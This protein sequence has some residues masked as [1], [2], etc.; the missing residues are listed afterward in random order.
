MDAI[1]GIDVGTSSTK[2]VGIRP[3]GSIIAALRARGAH[4]ITDIYDVL[5]AFL[6]SN[7]LTLNDIRQV[8]LTGVG[9]SYAEQGVYDLPT[10]MVDEFSASA[11]GALTLSGH[12]SG[13][14][15]TMG[16]G[17][18]LLHVD[19]SGTVRHLCGSGVG[20]GTLSGLCRGLIGTGQFEAI[21]KLSVDGNLHH[22]NLTIQDV[23]RNPAPTLDPSLTA[24]NFANLADD[25]TT[26]DLAAGV[27]NM[28]LEFIGTMT[29]LACQC[30]NTNHVILIGAMATLSMAI[31]NFELFER[32]YGIHYTIPENAAFATAIG[33]ARYSLKNLNNPH[34]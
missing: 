21:D 12:S 24:A 20:G 1:L 15:A 7:Q 31:P 29:V 11:T 19:E 14:I 6:T 22:I 9:A 13:I 3:D 26:S 25:A 32:V 34:V 4:Q 30:C 2:I 10:H 28:I 33:A 16:T 23:C 5:D 17:T 18:A 8:A 27:C